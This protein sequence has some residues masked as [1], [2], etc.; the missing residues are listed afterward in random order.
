MRRTLDHLMRP[1]Q[2]SD[3]AKVAALPRVP[4][5]TCTAT[6]HPPTFG[7]FPNHQPRRPVKA[8]MDG[9]VLDHETVETKKH[10]SRAQVKI[11]KLDDLR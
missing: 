2:W 8:S 5:R 7:S 9:T 1:R 4:M 3:P 11:T 6:C 10:A